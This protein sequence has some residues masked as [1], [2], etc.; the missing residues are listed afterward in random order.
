MLLPNIHDIIQAPDPNNPGGTRPRGIMVRDW[1]TMPNIVHNI[2]NAHW[3]QFGGNV[4]AAPGGLI[5]VVV[6]QNIA[7]G[8]Q[9][10]HYYSNTPE[11]NNYANPLQRGNGGASARR[12]IA[13]GSTYCPQRFLADH[14]VASFKQWSA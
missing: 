8:A 11:L 7:G 5:R 12:N 9:T 10:V 4:K 3:N 13:C 14:I 1:N 2:L 6:T